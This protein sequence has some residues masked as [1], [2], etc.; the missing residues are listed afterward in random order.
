MWEWRGSSFDFQRQ[1]ESIGLKPTDIDIIVLN[2][3]EPDHTEVLRALVNSAPNVKIVT[4]AK[5]AELVE[6]F[7][8]ISENIQ[9]VKSGD[10]L[11]LGGKTLHFVEVPY[12]HWPETMVTYLAEDKI[13]FSCDAFGSFG[14]LDG[15]IFDDE[16]SIQRKAFFQRETLRYYANIVAV[17]S[18]MVLKAI[19]KL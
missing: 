10:Q 19:D 7:Y 4:T 1:L 8:G 3:L 9:K 15:V 12:V 6:E 14:C 17:Y 18:K 2:H 16:L 11:D 13:L 5:G